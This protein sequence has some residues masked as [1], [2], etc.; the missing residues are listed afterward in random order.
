MAG[1][2]IHKLLVDAVARMKDLPARIPGPVPAHSLDNDYP[3]CA[4]KLLVDVAAAVQKGM[5]TLQD[6]VSL[7]FSRVV[8]D[9]SPW[10][11]ENSSKLEALPREVG[12]ICTRVL[13][14]LFLYNLP[15]HRNGFI[16]P[17]IQE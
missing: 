2:Q 12:C 13:E 7:S 4:Y 9:V 8:S 6:T 16:F 3:V 5:T 1:V 10:I 17:E 14:Q 11:I 15:I